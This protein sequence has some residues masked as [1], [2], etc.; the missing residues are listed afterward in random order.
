MKSH[1]HIFPPS[2]DGRKFQEAIDILNKLG[3]QHLSRPSLN[4]ISRRYQEELLKGI[5]YPGTG[6]LAMIDTGLSPFDPEKVNPS[7]KVL[8]LEVGG[9]NV[10]VAI[11]KADNEGN[12]RIQNSN[13]SSPCFQQAPISQ[14]V[15]SNPKDFIRAMMDPVKDILAGQ[16]FHGLG[17]VYSFPGETCHTQNGVDVVPYKHMAKGFS[18]EGI[19]DVHI[20]QTFIEVLRENLTGWNID[21][22]PDSLKIA[23]MNDTVAVLEDNWGGVVATGFNLALSYNGKI[24]NSESGGFNGIPQTIISHIVNRKS[25]NP[26]LQ[27]AEKTNIRNVYRRFHT[28]CGRSIG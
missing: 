8:V 12:V 10:R 11:V 3:A 26:G 18:V 22:L 17:I 13:N 16:T 23:V 1:E 21:N 14:K 4:A 24:Y 9:T 7:H 15:Y 2:P 5:R 19:E 6:S 25:T 27:P 20:G 28:N